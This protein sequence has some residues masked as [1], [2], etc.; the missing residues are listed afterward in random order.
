[1]SP[2]TS[3][4]QHQ[5]HHRSVPCPP[6]PVS[7]SINVITGQSPVPLHQSLSASTSS[8][9]SPL[10]PYTSLYQHQ[11]HHRSVP[12][13]PT[14]VSISINVITGQS[15]VPLH[16]SLSASTSSQVS[17]LSPY[18]SL[19]QHQR[20]HRSVP[21]PPTPVSI[22]INVITGQSPVPQ[23]QSLSASTSSQVSPLSPYTSL[24]QHQRL[25]RSVPCPPTPVSISINVITGQSHVPLHQS[26]LASTSSQVSPLSPYTSLYQHQR[27][28]RS[29]PCPPTPV[30]ISIN[31]ITGQ[32]PVPLHQSLS[33]STS[34]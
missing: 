25:H 5:R 22:S 23:H 15:P 14:P 2:Y 8:Q 33:A 9:V 28:H 17:P 31:V 27:H 29:V 3:L 1:M 24:Y 12:C 26:L 10:S 21:C 13:P 30:S 32:S 16:Q 4:Y 34:S 19:Y 11:R 7:I 6:T 18:T 20:H